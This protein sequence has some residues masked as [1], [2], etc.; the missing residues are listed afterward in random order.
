MMLRCYGLEGT[1]AQKSWGRGATTTRSLRS[2]ALV[3][4]L[5]RRYGLEPRMCGNT[6]V[7]NIKRILGG[8]DAG[9]GATGA[10]TAGVVGTAAW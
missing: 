4:T 1:N 10:V 8:Y 9:T 6:Y 3:V 2:G 5:L 7:S